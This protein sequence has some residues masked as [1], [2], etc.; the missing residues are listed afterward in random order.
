MLYIVTALYEEALPFLKHYGLKKDSSCTHLEC[1]CSEDTRLLITK[2]G[3]IRA[4]AAVSSF[5]TAFPP[6]PQDFLISVGV[7][8]CPDFNVPVG[9]MFC[10]QSIL[11]E[12]SGRT[13][14]PELLFRVPFPEAS[15]TTVSHVLHDLSQTS[16][17]TPSSEFTPYHTVPQ[18][19][20]MEASGVYTAAAMYLKTHQMLFLR[21]VSDHIS[22]LSEPAKLRTRVTA[23]IQDNLIPLCD[24]LSGIIPALPKV[25]TFSAEE[26]ALFESIC[27]ALRLSVTSSGRLKHLLHY[28]SLTGEPYSDKVRAILAAPLATPCH[29]KKEGLQYL[30]QLF[31][32][33]L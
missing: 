15:L 26:N 8:A 33:L 25:S 21:A 28:L 7:C 19:F 9:S 14:Y 11:D 18:L 30:E 10:I 22:D 23:C 12:P 27:K 17:G 20:D 24:C 2:P 29:T 3:S 13:F 16:A 5:L 1:Y 4:A 31:K 32:Q 6:Q